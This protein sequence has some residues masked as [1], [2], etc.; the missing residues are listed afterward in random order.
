MAEEQDETT[1]GGEDG[2]DPSLAA[3][4][5]STSGFGGGEDFVT[6][7]GGKKKASPAMVILL[8]VAILGGGGYM[9]WKNGPGA[10]SAA[11]TDPNVPGAAVVGS[12]DE[13]KRTINEFLSGGGKDLAAIEQMLH[14][15]EQ[16]V[17]QFLTYPSMTQVPLADLHTNPFRFAAPAAPDAETAVLEAKKAREALRTKAMKS[18]QSLRVDSIMLGKSGT[19]GSAII[20]GIPVKAGGEVEGFTVEEVRQNSVVIHDANFRFELKL[21]N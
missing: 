20:N 5:S 4:M 3:S 18:A 7:G 13:A 21:R 11:T 2:L 10:A 16:V 15:T 8:V 1:D 12:T 9:A 14:N 6:D 17:K 19:G